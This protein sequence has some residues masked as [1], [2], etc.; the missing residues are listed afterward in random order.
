MNDLLGAQQSPFTAETCMPGLV[1]T[2]ST[3]DV[4]MITDTM[5]MDENMDKF[6]LMLESSEQ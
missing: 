6:E 1:P 2:S 5:E 4:G 3:E